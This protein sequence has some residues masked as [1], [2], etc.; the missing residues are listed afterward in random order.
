MSGDY[1][2]LMASHPSP[3]LRDEV[4]ALGDDVHASD[5]SSSEPV[6][7]ASQE[8]PQANLDR[9]SS[10]WTPR[11]FLLVTLLVVIGLGGGVTML[12]VGELLDYVM[13]KDTLVAVELSQ[14]PPSEPLSGT[15][16]RRHG[17]ETGGS[18]TITT[19]SGREAAGD[20]SAPNH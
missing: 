16:Y 11:F 19:G 18:V 8:V 15:R 5:V 7:P 6:P 1:S 4:T 3:T 14:E 12:L 13:E 20:R 17:R 2:E 10:V 9:T